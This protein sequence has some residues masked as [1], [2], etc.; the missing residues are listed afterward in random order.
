MD[1]SPGPAEPPSASLSTSLDN[2]V[3]ELTPI[4]HSIQEISDH[5]PFS[6][7]HVL[8]S[9][10]NILTLRHTLIDT[11]RPRE[12]KDVFRNLGGFQTLLGLVRRLAELYNPKALSKDERKIL[13]SL[14]KDLLAVLSECLRD[15]SGNRRYFAKRIG[16]EERWSIEESLKL[17]V[18]KPKE[19]EIPDSDVEQ[20]YGALLAAALCQETVTEIFTVLRTKYASDQLAPAPSSI[21]LGVDRLLN[22]TETVELHEFIGPFLRTWFLQSARSIQYPIQRLAIPACF[23]KLATNSRRNIIALHATGILS[24]VLRSI[25]DGRFSA[26]EKALYQELGDLLCTEGITSL[27]DVI[28][29]YRQSCVSIEASKFLLRAM[30][31][32]K[33]PPCIQF[34]MVPHGYSSIELSTLGRPF[35]PLSSSG[36]T[37]SI[38]AHFD[39]FDPNSHTT[40]FGAFD[41]KQTCFVLAYLEK[42]TRHFILQTSI[43]GSRPSVRFKS[44]AFKQG[45]WYHICVIH[46]RARA[47]TPSRAS[48]FVDGEFI[49][50]LRIDYPT[51]PVARPPN[52]H[53]RVQAF[54]G[55][56]QDLAIRIGKGVCATKWSVA[57]AILSEE[58]FSDDLISVF[59][60]LGPRYHGN[61]QDCLGSFQTY[62]ASAAL[63]L[64]NESLHP[65]KE[66][67]SDIVTAIRQRASILVHESSFLMNIS[68][69]TVLDD[70]D[71]NYV[72]ESQLIKFLSRQAA[73]NLHGM[74]NTGGNA[75]AIN[76]AIP[77]INDALT[78]SHGMAILAG[79][80]VVSVPQSLD[81]ASWRI[82]GCVAVHL[83]MLHAATCPEN[84]ILAVQILF[85]AIQSNWRNS[86]AMERDNGYGILALLLREKLGFPQT[87]QPGGSK[88]S[89][90]CSDNRERS[91]LA[92]ELL[93]HIL[94]FIGYNFDEPTKSIITNPLAYRVLLVDL[95]IWRYGEPSLLQM[96]YS[97]FSTFSTESQHRRFNAR[98][99]SRM[100][101]NKR[102][103][104]ALK[105]E[106]FTEETLSLFIPAFRSLFESCVSAELL[107]SLSLFITFALH[108]EKIPKLQTKKSMRFNS[109][110]RQVSSASDPNLKKGMPKR[111]IGLELLRMYTDFL[112]APDDFTNIKRFARAVTNKWLLYLMCEDAPEAVVMATK[113]LARLIIVHGGSYSKKLAQKTGGYIIMKNRLKRWWNVFALWPICLAILFGLDTA[114]VDIDTLTD[115]S[116]LL[117]MLIHK[118]RLDVVF[119]EVLPVIAD[120]LRTGLEDSIF[121]NASAKDRAVLSNAITFLSDVHSKSPGFRDFAATSTYTQKLLFVLFPMTGSRTVNA[122]VELHYREDG[123]SSEPNYAKIQH[124]VTPAPVLRTSRVAPSDLALETHGSLRRSSS[125]VLISSDRPQYAPSSAQLYRTSTPRIDRD[126]SYENNDLVL[127][128]RA[129]IFKVFASQ[130]IYRKDFTGLGLFL[131]TPPSNL[132]PQ[133]YFVSWLLR[134][135]LTELRSTFSANENLL[136]EPRVLTSL[137]RFLTHVGESLFEGWFLNGSDQTLDLAG[138]VLEYLSRPEIASLKIIRLC[139]Q[140]ITTVRSVLFKVILFELSKQD[141]SDSLA[142]LN[143]LRYWQTIILAA[144]ESEAEY[145]KLFFY[146]LYIK[147]VSEK[148]EIRLAAAT[149]WRIILVQ[150]PSEMASILSHAPLSLQHRLT[151]G[152]EELVGMDDAA[153]LSWIDDQRED[154]DSFFFRSLSKFWDNFVQEENDRTQESSRSRLAKRKDRLKQWGQEEHAAEEILRKHST[155]FDHWTSN[156]FASEFLKHQRLLQDQH[157]NYSFMWSSFSRL[158]EDLYRFGGV[159]EKEGKKRWRLDQTEGR[160]RMRLRVI[161][162]DSDERQDYQPKR[163]ASEPPVMRLNTQLQPASSSEALHNT[164]TAAG[165]AE[166]SADTGAVA[167]DGED[168][169]A[170]EDSFEMIDDP[171]IDIDEY[172]DKNRKVMRSLQR[173]DQVQ[174]VCNMSRIIGL[175]ACEGLL[176]IGKNAVYIL[177]NY[178]QRADGEIVNV[179]QA[180]PEERDPFVRMIAG[181]ESSEQKFR[182]HEVRNWKWPDLISVSK[183]RFLFRD[184]ALE[185]FFTDGRSY[186]LTLISSRARD[187]LHN[188]LCAHAPQ[189]GGNMNV[190]RPEDIWRFEMLRVQDDAPQ[191]LGSKF[192]SVFGQPSLNPAT[193]K[194][195]KGEMSNFHYLMLI[196][197]LAGRTFNDLTQYPVF[198]WV[199]ADYTSEELDLDDH[200]SFRD[201][202]KPMGCQ[203]PEREAEFRER[204][205]SFAEMG[206]EN[207]PAFHY[208]THYSSAMIVSSYLIRLQ[209]FVK[210]YLLLQGGTFDHADR[211]FYS[212]GKAWESASRG[213]LSDVRELIPEFFY[214]PEFLVNSNNY[215]FGL[216]QNMTKAIDS[217]E[218]PPWAKGDP[219]IFIA[220][221]REALES[222]YVTEH[223]H[224]WIDLVFGFKQKGEAAIEA[225][226]VFH[227]LS[228]QGARDLDNIEDPVE[229]LATIGIIHN[230]GQTPHQVFQRA[231]ARRD[232]PSRKEG[233]LDTLAESLT[234]VP[235]SLLDIHE[236]VSSMSMKNER[237]LCTPAFRL[238]V[239]PSYDKYLEWGFSD[240]SVRFYAADSRKIL[241]H[242]EHLHVGQLSC[243]LFADS[244]TL[245]TAGSDCTISIWSFGSNGKMMELQPLACL[246]G[247]RT[248]ISVLAPSR[249]FSTLLSASSDGQIMLWDLNRRCFVRE[250]RAE[251][252]VEC[253]RINDRTGT[254]M[255]CRG[256]RIS[257]YSLN[258]SL[259]IDQVICETDDDHII[260]C[261][262]Y[263]GESNEWLE[264]E[265]LFTGHQRGVVNVWSKVIRNGRFDLDLIRQLHHVDHNKDTGVNV[266]AG[267]SCILPLPHS[268]YTGDDTGRVIR[269]YEWDCIQRRS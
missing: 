54:L 202:S 58:T 155:T 192:A 201:L 167:A 77:A 203:N 127:E 5:Q 211:L 113:I 241:G 99:L 18:E 38:W 141:D 128:V 100:R 32:S 106:E 181:R 14:L 24:S 70:D 103:L 261:A 137:A 52:K 239:P 238:N 125:F 180:P 265:L 92:I 62:K 166:E 110:A 173:G 183:R 218:L 176:I 267:I 124:S 132:E 26:Q 234:R 47:A 186:L 118:R 15:H 53:P 158:S 250:L 151:N 65:G 107:R 222:P 61:Y 122:E 148:H 64:R 23:C 111:Q 168:K 251:G 263:E 236:R 160:S 85:E 90:V 102:F 121:N 9:T 156:I 75:I 136:Q 243:V 105:G 205:K 35:P 19:E 31:S 98:R 254:I 78:H 207:A 29:L 28:Y 209:P 81:D 39:Q 214:L 60:H 69:T 256:G 225:A 165:F 12:A 116:S 55:T 150:R 210:S 49:E 208:G 226:N 8:R 162:D 145:L 63:N 11:A 174:S 3:A 20:I 91:S 66:E 153:F 80:P 109:R 130:I 7:D 56:P 57:N 13:L 266:S 258:G 59:Y 230:F 221:H 82:G 189:F 138:F 196:N 217:V 140:A 220:K 187:E 194:W 191:S 185:M 112:C 40:I 51:V 143:R 190:T 198:P 93:R 33:E 46:R 149:L 144:G 21:R 147:S 131:K 84:T 74:I 4:L 104:D 231:H 126:A 10:E 129:I 36:Y 42:D 161:P 253:A 216:R 255:I 237:L 134:G 117:D 229:R 41:A 154:L 44:I 86:E 228:Y 71:S 34:D 16:C 1:G 262:F 2:V 248:T 83:N 67:N 257:L 172:E 199:L 182:E 215:D 94:S 179:W 178:F 72:N 163:K 206:D 120:M 48:L 212:V 227:H 213:N 115:L 123:P 171:R 200:K 169:S 157:D 252:P 170:L 146:Q 223:L 152:F 249:S 25:F 68:P 17:F 164:P 76:G 6:I 30:Q 244:Q 73:K 269:K 193:R 96:Y 159:L 87:A 195:I 88:T 101:V 108:D 95:D 133:A 240:G 245:I 43:N 260:S 27:D 268:V 264:R 184:V 50:Q 246:Y 139:N 142:F 219:K 204:Y 188:Q 114:E 247:H 175:E 235:L 22:S 233:C 97:Q 89:T 119:S 135:T 177:D 242:F 224:E 45:Q 197:T 37:I 259:L 79:E 232:D